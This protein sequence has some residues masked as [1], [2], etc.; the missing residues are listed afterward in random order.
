MS[1]NWIS[2]FVSPNT[3]MSAFDPKRT[4]G[5]VMLAVGEIAR[6]GTARI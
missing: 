1:A 4:L 2:S 3:L 6:L 5:R